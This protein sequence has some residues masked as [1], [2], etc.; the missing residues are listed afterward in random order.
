VKQAVALVVGAGLLVL[1]WLWV[2]ARTEGPGFAALEVPG[3]D[4]DARACLRAA[5]QLW[6]ARPGHYDPAR[7]LA[8]LGLLADRLDEPSFA[9][10]ASPSWLASF[11]P[12]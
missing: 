9:A 6:A 2:G 12:R 11:A 5:G 3:E 8:F 7:V 4:Q 1:A 10:A